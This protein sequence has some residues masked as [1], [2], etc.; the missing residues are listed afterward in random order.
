[1]K[2]LSLLFTIA[3]AVITTVQ[4]SDYPYVTDST[5]FRIIYASD[6]DEE[7]GHLPSPAELRQLNRMFTTAK[8]LITAAHC[9]TL[10]AKGAY[11]VSRAFEQ[12]QDQ[13][14]DFTRI[15][16]RYIQ[17]I[18]A[19]RGLL[20]NEDSVEK[21]ALLADLNQA[22]TNANRQEVTAIQAALIKPAAHRSPQE[23]EQIRKLIDWA[24]PMLPPTELAQPAAAAAA[25]HAAPIVHPAPVPQQ[26]Q[27]VSPKKRKSADLSIIAGLSTAVEAQ[28]K[29]PRKQNRSV[30]FNQQT[31]V[32]TYTRSRQSHGAMHGEN[33]PRQILYAT[34]AAIRGGFSEQA[35][36]ATP[37]ASPLKGDQ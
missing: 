12:L 8:R 1:M 33:T 34:D 15:G 29:S 37:K 18:N 19:L 26:A 20:H 6:R 10:D 11:F 28:R 22:L 17:A 13:S 9:V 24:L 16:V 5:D 14:D 21:F 25:A 32:A 2:K 35:H 23:N 4:A 27:S 31:Q 30:R 7:T 3:C 36:I